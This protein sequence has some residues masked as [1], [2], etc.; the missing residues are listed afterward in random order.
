MDTPITVLAWDWKM[1]LDT[2]DRDQLVKFYS[3]HVD[4]GP[5]DLA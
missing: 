4:R 5:E 3:A 2:F 1:P